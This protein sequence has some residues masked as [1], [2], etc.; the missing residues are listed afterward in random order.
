MADE[1]DHAT[2]I[3]EAERDRLVGKVRGE[4]TG[5]GLATCI[6][7]GWEIPAARRAANPHATRCIDCQERHEEAGH[8]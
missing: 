3:S 4:L 1:A 2:A 7:C 6:D 5:P 8:D